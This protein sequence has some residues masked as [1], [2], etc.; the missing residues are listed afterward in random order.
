[1]DL[2]ELVLIVCSC[3]A[4]LILGMI[5]QAIILRPHRVELKRLRQRQVA[6]R[7]HQQRMQRFR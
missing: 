4:S 2:T 3:L 1:M 6:E 5:I 7:E